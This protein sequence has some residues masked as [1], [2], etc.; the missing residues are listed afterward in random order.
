MAGKF[1]EWEMETLINK[2]CVVTENVFCHHCG[3]KC[4]ETIHSS[5]YSFC[6]QGCVTV[7][8]IL[9]SNGMEKYYSLENNPGVTPLKDTQDKYTFL[10]DEETAKKLYSFE[11]EKVAQVELSIPAIHCISCIWLIENLNKLSSGVIRSEVNFGKKSA[12][13]VF[14]KGKTDLSEIAELLLKLGYEADFNMA[15]LDKQKKSHNRS[16]VSRISVAGFCFGNIMLFSFPHYLGLEIGDNESA[17]R[18]FSFMNLVI[19][20][21]VFF[22]CGSDYLKAAHTAYK[23]KTLSLDL[24]IF[25]G[26]VAL[27]TQS[28]YE[29]LT[30]TGPGYMDSLAGLVFFLLLGRFFQ[31][32]TYD[33][34]SFERDYKSFFPLSA[35][36]VTGQ[37][38]Q[39]VPLD[40]INEGDILRI[41]NGELIPSDSTLLNGKASI[42]YS[43]V[44]GEADLQEVSNGEKLFAGGRQS[45]AAIDIKV[46]SKVNH[47]YLTELW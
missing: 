42:D 1:L 14:S 3:E 20:I 2:S 46:L 41:R 35:S 11:N 17:A 22:Y 13:I 37:K 47:S 21:P 26:M 8:D 12:R 40:R 4:E 31:Q 45:G 24:P 9:A 18:F 5:G 34:L 43:F 44:T 38:V 10:K 28:A 27:F 30:S 29:I 36:L 25:V 39:S 6:C 19:A 16:L 7:F 15:D 32:K 23:S 33:R